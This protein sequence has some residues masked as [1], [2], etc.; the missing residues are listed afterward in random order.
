MKNTPIGE[1][2]TVLKLKAL[3]TAIIQ[4]SGSQVKAITQDR[5]AKVKK[6][7]AALGRKKAA[8]AEAMEVI[9]DVQ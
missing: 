4:R 8:E 1:S 9:E 5:D 2:E 6:I 3:R 7:D